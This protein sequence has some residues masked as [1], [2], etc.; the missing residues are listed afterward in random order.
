MN[1]LGFFSFLAGAL[2]LTIP[3]YALRLVRRFG[4]QRVG[5]FLVAA[6]ASLGL[7]HLL[8]P[9]RTLRVSS[10]SGAT[11][12]AIYAIGSV[13]LLIGMAHVESLVS[14]R[15]EAAREEKNLH[16]QLEMELEARTKTNEELTREI[17]RREHWEKALAESEAQYRFLFLQNP[18]PMW[19]FD[20]RSFQFLA[21]NKT[22]LSQY[23]FSEQEFMALGAQG[24]VSSEARAGFLKNIA[25][26]CFGVE[27]RGCWPLR[28]QDGT[29]LEVELTAVDLKY[30]GCPSRLV[31][32]NDISARRRLE[33]QLLEGQRM[34]LIANVAGGVAHHFNNILTAI[35]GHSD[36]LLQTSSREEATRQLNQ[37]AAATHRGACLTRQLLAAGGQQMVN[38]EPLNLN[39]ILQRLNPMLRRLLGDS[40]A[41]QSSLGA[42]L[43]LTIA[44]LRAVENMVVSLVLNAR[45]AMSGGG[46]LA[47]STKAVWITEAEA[48]HHHHAGA[49]EFVCLRVCDTGCGM[50]P[51]VQARLFE[52]FFTTKQAGQAMGLGLASAYG[53]ARQHL[54][55]V[56]C[57]SEVGRGTEVKVFLPC[58][59]RSTEGAGANLCV[60]RP[61][62]RQTV[63]FVEPDDRMRAL[64]RF[65]LNRQGYS[66]I[67]ADTASLA[68]SLWE[69]ERK[70]IDLVLTDIALPGGVSGVKFVGKLQAAK[71]GL[72]VIF[73]R[74]SLEIK[75]Q[76]LALSGPQT[77]LAKP[78][79]AEAL[80]PAVEKC[81]A[82]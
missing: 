38:L 42:D 18:Q 17:T 58:A 20:L 49:A 36:L 31:L 55:W 8:E 77:V 69:A 12:D 2:Q 21:V 57:V 1:S 76:A 4:A 15:I 14:A 48:R 73:V 81:L 28:K 61:A 16:H 11:L 72:K 33:Q 3:P 64:G 30:G 44:D 78:Y 65:I 66:V 34:E 26:P 74:G 75:E 80:L 27:F 71:P 10:G 25:Q 5:W 37:L 46:T 50:S 29:I 24:L 7:L 23:G 56:E 67:E 79:T 63:L 60:A 32:A 40:I 39:D 43:P 41:L 53:A 13:L 19:I 54:G 70:K 35:S 6:F 9:L 59:P 22:A 68:L 47:L 62:T 82:G 52:P 51:E 45:D